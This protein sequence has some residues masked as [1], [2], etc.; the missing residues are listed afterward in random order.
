M[1]CLRTIIF[2]IQAVLLG[3]EGCVSDGVGTW[4]QIR[5]HLERPGFVFEKALDF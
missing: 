2:S 1:F 5:T 3:G 4:A